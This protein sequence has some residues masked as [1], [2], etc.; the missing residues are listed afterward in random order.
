MSACHA[1]MCLNWTGQGCACLVMDIEPDLGEQQDV[2]A[3]AD[4]APTH[5]LDSWDF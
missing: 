1:E 4:R 2:E 3:P 5:G